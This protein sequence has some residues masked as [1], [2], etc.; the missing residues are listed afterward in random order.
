MTQHWRDMGQAEVYQLIAERGIYEAQAAQAIIDGQN[1][2]AEQHR[3]SAMSI[4]RA[5]TARHNARAKET[6]ATLKASQP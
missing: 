2:L 4:T 3:D 5:I 6:R 1:W